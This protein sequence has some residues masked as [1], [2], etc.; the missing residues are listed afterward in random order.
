VAP[1]Q[2]AQPVQPLPAA[3][4]IDIP[5]PGEVTSPV[6]V[7]VKGSGS[8]LP[9]NNVVVQALNRE[10]GVLA[11]G[12]TTL[13]AD[14]P[15]GAGSWTVALDL[16]VTPGTPG[17]IYAFSPSPADGSIVAEASVDVTYGQA[18]QQPTPEPTPEPTAAPPVAPATIA[19][20]IPQ[21]GENI[22]PKE[23]VVVGSGS[24]LRENNVVVQALDDQGTVL[25]EVPTILGADGEWR[26]TLD[27]AVAPGTLG[28][29]YA[30]SPSPADG[31]NVAESRVSV[32]YGQA[33]EVTPT[34][35]PPI[36]SA[37]IRINI[38]QRD[39][40]VS[41]KE[42]VVVGSGSGLPENNVV[43]QALDSQGKVLAEVATVVDSGEMGGQGEWR[44]TLD[45]AVA[46]GTQGRIYAFS[47]SPAT[48]SNVAEASVPVTYGETNPEPRIAITSPTNGAQVNT[49]SGFLVSGTG[50]NLFE[51]NVVVEARDADGRRLVQR[52]TTVDANGNW[53]VSLY[54]GAVDGPGT[55]IAFA[56]S[57]AD[58]SRMAESK[59]SV[60]FV[61]TPTQPVRPSI[62]IE[63]PANGARINA[64]SGFS[65]NGLAQGVFEGNVIVQA[66]DA[67]GSLLD[68]V[69]T[70]A[71][72]NGNWS[73]ALRFL[74]PSGTVGSIYAFSTSPADG[75]VVAD[76]LVRVTFVSA[77]RV[78]TDWPVYVVQRGDTLFS[79]AQR[80]GSTVGELTFAN[81]LSNPNNITVGQR[82]HVPRLPD[83]G[84]V[85]VEPEIVITN[86]EAD[87]EL[88]LDEPVVIEGSAVGV[89]PGNIFVRLLDSTGVVVDNIHGEV[90]EQA[91]ENGLWTWRAELSAGNVEPGKRG[92]VFAYAIQATD[93][94]IA[95]YA[96]TPVVY[97]QAVDGPFVTIDSPAP[98]S[99][100]GVD[101]A[102]T[103]SGRG[104][105][106]FE[107]NVI[108]QALDN[109]GNV[110]AEDYGTIAVEEI[111]DTGDW[112][113]DL[114]VDY[115]GRGRI[116]AFSTSPED[117]ST[118][119][120]AGVDVYFGDPTQ[121]ESVAV[122]THP[123]PNTVYTYKNR[124]V[125][126]A[127]YAKGVLQDQ[128]YVTIV[129]DQGNVAFLIPVEVDPTSGFW[130]TSLD[131]QIPVDRD[132]KYSVNVAA[133]SGVNGAVFA[134]DRV[135]VETR[136]PEA[137]VTGNV[138][139]DGEM[140]LPD[141]AVVTVQVADVSKAD[142][143]AEVIGEQVI[144][145]PGQLPIPFV[146][147]Y[148][149]D[150]IDER[151]TYA[152]SVRITDGE[153]NLL[154]TST[155]MIPVITNGAPTA[156]VD[157]P[158]EKVQ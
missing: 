89:L 103:V 100:V 41:P 113:V 12:V 31:S 101:G 154:F 60:T 67:Y 22:S 78:R 79:I 72:V 1:E 32:T 13:D 38:P 139:A 85:T 56:P 68:Q 11:E 112:S 42:V 129:D 35:V 3:I 153:D 92:H 105:G 108:V 40:T 95:A 137:A 150:V 123:L 142:A 117:G 77:C 9:E 127:G 94:T 119:A 46:P 155:T 97:G 7:V 122:I 128:V 104:A 15:G 120:E 47:P 130:T 25:A 138:V 23:V 63:R 49:D 82:L 39:E 4:S 151:F 131:V 106:L 116:V 158:V 69:V 144:A 29:I 157:V 133:T 126:A 51:G 58:G 99:Q 75:R 76:D 5:L 109:S 27:Y 140:T 98:Y 134:G 148:D 115:I 28:S 62:R 102:I 55:I 71:D 24:S 70:T 84:D 52:P 90:V 20:N 16:G 2:P 36:A 44:A 107:G 96:L 61:S 34:P 10:G 53:S 48:G 18:E 87:A 145:L 45:Y 37:S 135:D 91:D 136:A 14:A 26:A 114:T 65:V 59:V 54:T 73:T 143:A 147:E 125:T 21:Q 8:G 19:I 156:N 57:P 141:D 132:R 111:G 30:F 50:A 110:L 93:G 66:R 83:T 121:E 64:T 152:V 17:S 6:Q 118:M 74:I 33:A 149:P 88:P 81:C 146:V 80:T 86:T 43:V 124:L